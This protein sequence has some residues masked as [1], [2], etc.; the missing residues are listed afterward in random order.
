MAAARAALLR[1]SASR[2]GLRG[3]VAASMRVANPPRSA[4]CVRGGSASDCRPTDAAKSIR[5][6]C[7][8]C[9]GFLV[10]KHPV[11]GQGRD[12]DVPVITSDSEN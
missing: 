12:R 11:F 8:A 1:G 4:P 7:R 10:P 5:V 6:I 2:H 9:E 3:R